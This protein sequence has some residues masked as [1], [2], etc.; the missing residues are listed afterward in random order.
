MEQRPMS[1]PS[2]GFLARV[3]RAGNRLPDPVMIFVWLKTFRQ[4]RNIRQT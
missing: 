1:T 4:R 3:E 2:S